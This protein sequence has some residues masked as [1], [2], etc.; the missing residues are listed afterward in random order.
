MH[1]FTQFAIE[2]NE[3]EMGIAPT[4]SRRRP[5]QRL[6]ELG[7]FGAANRLK[8]CLEQAQRERIKEMGK[9]YQPKWFVLL[10]GLSKEEQQ[11]LYKFTGEYWK[12]KETQNWDN[13]PELFAV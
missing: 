1:N 13:C 10:N 2:L 5:D 9:D 12:A 3:E 6:C 11:P 8:K 7:E 4:D